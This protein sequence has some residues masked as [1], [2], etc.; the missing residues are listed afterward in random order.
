KESDMNARKLLPILFLGLLGGCGTANNLASSTGHAAVYGGVRS[1]LE[2][3]G[4]LIVPR[5]GT[6][7][8]IVNGV[9]A[10]V[11]LPL[12]AVGDT[13]TLPLTVPGSLGGAGRTP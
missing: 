7:R 10:A 5:P 8:P 11:D 2:K 3:I 6:E 4:D 13:V 1:D 12:S 9:V